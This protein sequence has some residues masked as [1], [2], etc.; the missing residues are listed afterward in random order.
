[1][2]VGEKVYL[3]P[4]EL[5][6]V[7]D[8]NKWKNDETTFKFLGGGF[9]PVSIDQQSK[10]MGSMIDLTGNNKRYI[11]CSIEDNN[12][13]G[14]VGLY[15]ISWI[16]RN[17]EVGIY[18]GSKEYRGK[19]HATET[20]ELLERFAKNYLNLRKLKLNVV[21][22]NN[23]AMR[24]WSKLGFL[25]VGELI[26]ERYINGKYYNLIIMEKFINNK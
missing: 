3:R 13:L 7:D 15:G 10:W 24:L 23:N 18:I 25:Q 9:N 6:D 12:P 1:M 16:H 4:I 22:N 21:K 8:L 5:K 2:L 11:I 17:A 20:Y 19:G 14:M 26:A